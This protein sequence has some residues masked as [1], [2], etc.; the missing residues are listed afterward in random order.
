MGM[1]IQHVGTGWEWEYSLREPGGMDT[2]HVGIGKT[3][4]CMLFPFITLSKNLE[5]MATVKEIIIVNM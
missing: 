4:S 3:G 2:R 1:G 5:V